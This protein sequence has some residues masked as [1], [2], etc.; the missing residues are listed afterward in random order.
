MANKKATLIAEIGCNHKGNMSIAKEL[1]KIAKI[2]IVNAITLKSI[3]LPEFL[4]IGNTV[5][6]FH[7]EKAGHNSELGLL[8]SPAGKEN[9]SLFDV[10]VFLFPMEGSVLVGSLF[11]SQRSTQPP[12]RISGVV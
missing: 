2:C 11:N 7:G 4:Y 3:A 6:N 12:N 10:T 1:I 5:L 9:S 8:T